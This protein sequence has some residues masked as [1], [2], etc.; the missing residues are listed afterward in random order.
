MRIQES[1]S[2]DSDDDGD[3]DDDD[4]EEQSVNDPGPLLGQ[5][6]VEQPI[7]SVQPDIQPVKGELIR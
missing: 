3:D 4:D 1:G 7:I 2:G 6:T 5:Q